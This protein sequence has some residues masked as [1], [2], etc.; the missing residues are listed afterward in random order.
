ML[1]PQV[2]KAAEFSCWKSMKV[3]SI[4]ESQISP[5]SKVKKEAPSL[6]I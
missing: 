6:L 1:D 2:E 4:K 5:G 3:K